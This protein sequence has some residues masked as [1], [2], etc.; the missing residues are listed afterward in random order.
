MSLTSQISRK[1]GERDLTGSTWESVLNDG[2]FEQLL[3]FSFKYRR[4]DS[5][6][7][8]PGNVFWGE[9]IFKVNDKL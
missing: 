3:G 4:V 5:L 1:T 8:T 2:S 7:Q 9:D 6:A